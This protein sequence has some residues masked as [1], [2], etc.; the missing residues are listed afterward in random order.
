MDVRL[1]FRNLSGGIVLKANA[2]SFKYSS[3]LPLNCC[4]VVLV[5]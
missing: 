4:L 5:A 2:I 1:G 3:S